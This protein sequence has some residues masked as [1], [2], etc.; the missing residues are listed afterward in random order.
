MVVVVFGFSIKFND[1]VDQGARKKC[2]LEL[3][4]YWINNFNSLIAQNNKFDHS[5]PSIMNL[6]LLAKQR[7]FW[8]MGL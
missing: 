1:L 6:K 7:C 5:S 2:A 4:F 8:V 3:Q